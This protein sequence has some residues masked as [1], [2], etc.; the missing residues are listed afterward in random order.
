MKRSS[1]ALSLL[2]M[3]YTNYDLLAQNQQSGCK[4]CS[5]VHRQFDFWL[6]EWIVFSDEKMAG[7][8]TISI[9]QDSCLIQEE[10]QSANNNYSGTSYSFYSNN[11]DQWQQLW[12]DNQGASLELSG[13]YEN[14]IMIL[15]SEPMTNAKGERY[16]NRITWTP[17]PAG[18]V[19]QHWEISKD[20]GESWETVFDGLYKQK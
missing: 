16:L 19:R 7:T 1:I 17:F 11:N 8:N 15:E 13:R 6:G 12:V 4:C 20:L 5:S 10:W 14:G 2:V 18:P 3:L 9:R